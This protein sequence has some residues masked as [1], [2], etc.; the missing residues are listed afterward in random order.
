[1]KVKNQGAGAD[2]AANCGLRVHLQTYLD[3]NKLA[4]R[5]VT[6]N[7]AVS[8]CAAQKGFQEYSGSQ[9]GDS[10]H[11]LLTHAAMLDFASEQANYEGISQIVHGLDRGINE[12][13]EG[14]DQLPFELRNMESFTSA[15]SDILRAKSA[16]LAAAGQLTFEADDETLY[17]TVK[18]CQH[19]R[20]MLLRALRVFFDIADF[21][22]RLQAKLSIK[23]SSFSF[24]SLSPAN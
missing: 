6:I 21:E 13:L 9:L 5:S 24:Y 20:D 12:F 14:L 3:E 17:R 15:T 2:R 8:Q 11:Q 16:L 4:N 1:V 23:R 10:F 7:S 18:C 22:S 19:E